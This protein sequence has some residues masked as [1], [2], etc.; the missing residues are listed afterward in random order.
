M[1]I[2]GTTAGAVEGAA[3]PPVVGCAAGS[4]G[5]AGVW[6]EAK[7]STGACGAARGEVACDGL[8]CAGGVV[9]VT[10]VACDTSTGAPVM[11]VGFAFGSSVSLPV[12][13]AR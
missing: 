7:G 9:G 11:T 8:A 12:R 13:S 6:N 5:V 3:G 4:A 1:V 2:G 10:G